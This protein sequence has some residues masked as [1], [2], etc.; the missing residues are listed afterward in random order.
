MHIMDY[1]SY[2]KKKKKKKSKFLFPS[3]L[4][5]GRHLLGG[6]SGGDVW[7]RSGTMLVIVGQ[8]I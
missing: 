3:L 8:A 4:P 1:I 5:L 7:S 6:W 2:K